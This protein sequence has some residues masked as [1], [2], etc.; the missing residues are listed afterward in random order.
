MDPSSDNRWSG[1]NL[2]R[3]KTC[4]V[5][6]KRT[7]GSFAN[8]RTPFDARKSKGQRQ[9]TTMAVT[10]ASS[11]PRRW[12]GFGLY[13]AAVMILY[14]PPLRELAG[15]SARS[16]LYS[17]IPL[18]PLVSVLLLVLERR[19]VFARV[20]YAVAAG[21]TVAVVGVLVLRL[22]SWPQ[23]GGNHLV[24]TMIS[25]WM[26]VVGGFILF[27]GPKALREGLF[28]LAFLAFV[29]P[30]P[31]PLVDRIVQ[32]LLW[33]SG[34]FSQLFFQVSGASFV[35]EG[36]V[37]HFERVS[38]EIAP[39]CSGVR[40]SLALLITMTLAARLFLHRWWSRA[41]L[42]VFVLPLAMVKNA[43]RIVTLTLLAQYVDM[44][45]LTGSWLHSSGGFVFFGITLL[46]FGGI[47]F[48]LHKLESR[49]AA[50]GSPEKGG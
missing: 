4:P 36:L 14:F 50:A 23:D 2:S 25:V 22:W 46:L 40:S 28:P 13:M 15:L 42:M 17:H 47:L 1:G 49:S 26:A 44:R 34:A 45:F 16:E 19:Q 12:V 30:L 9:A 39:Q 18:V 37:F 24:V 48:G 33:G 20:D 7:P 31:Q 29:I 3:L 27:F 10:R 11:I 41:L 21:V 38:I 35:R 43:I 32:F 6:V 5:P 8:H